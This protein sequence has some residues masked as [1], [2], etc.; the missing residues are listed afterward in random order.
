M[1]VV[2]GVLSNLARPIAARQ[3]AASKIVDYPGDIK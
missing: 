1:L 3:I 2:P